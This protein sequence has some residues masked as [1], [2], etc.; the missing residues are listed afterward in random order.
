[1]KVIS[2]AGYARAGKD[3]FANIAK[4]I[5]ERNNYRFVR[6]AFADEVKNEI[7]KMLNN[8][9]FKLNVQKL[10][11]EEKEKIRPLFVI[12]ATQRRK[13][14][15]G[16]AYWIN[17]VDKQLNNIIYDFKNAGEST[18]RLVTLIPDCRYLNEVNWVHENWNGKVI[19]LR[20]YTKT[21]VGMLSDDKGNVTNTYSNE[22]DIAPNEEERRQDPMVIEKADYRIEWENKNAKTISA[23]MENPDLQKIVLDTLNA[24]SF[25]SGILR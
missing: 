17:V 10:T 1:M 8:N 20:R 4:V 9:G 15:D 14:S 19:H 23:A 12:W 3:T 6:V 25:F 13:E 7:Q 22:Y 16:E 21:V 5:L 24:T 2:I 18:D 11:A